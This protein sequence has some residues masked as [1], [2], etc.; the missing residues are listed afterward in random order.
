VFVLCCRPLLSTSTYT[1]CSSW[2]S[3]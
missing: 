2:G 3:R 1:R